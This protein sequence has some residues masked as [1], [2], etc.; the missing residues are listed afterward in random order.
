MKQRENKVTIIIGRRGSGKTT[1][2]QKAMKA[3]GLKILIVD[4]H[5]HP[6]YSEYQIIQPEQ[7]NYWIKNTKRIIVKHSN[8]SQVVAPV[9][10]VLKNTTVVFEDATKYIRKNLP[11]TLTDFVLDT[12]QKNV[13]IFFLYHSFSVVPPDLYKFT[14]YITVF[15]TNENIDTSKSKIAAYDIIEAAHKKVMSDKN[16]YANITVKIN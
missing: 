11:A 1:F 13:D 8:F 3:A 10:D 2:I 9:F 15:K 4:T 14:D 16:E 12:K 7:I 5:D 6:A